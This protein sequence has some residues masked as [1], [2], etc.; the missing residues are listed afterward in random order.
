MKEIG[1]N[2][3]K[4][5]KPCKKMGKVIMNQKKMKSIMLIVSMLL[6]LGITGIPI[7]SADSPPAHAVL[8]TLY[9]NNE[10]YN[11]SLLEIQITFGYETYTGYTVPYLYDPGY[12]RSLNFNVGVPSIHEGETGAIK[13][14]YSGKSYTP[15]DHPAVFIHVGYPVPIFID[16]NCTIDMTP[17]IPPE[18]G[19]STGG[20]GSSPVQNIKPYADASAG[21]PY[22]GYVN[23]PITFNGSKSYDPDGHIIAW[24]WTFDDGNSGT[25]EIANHI[26]TLEGTY[27]VVLK[28]TDNKSATDTDQTTAIITVA[29]N[30]P[31]TPTLT[32]DPGVSGHKNISY[33]F[34]AMS[35]DADND[36]IEYI[37]S[38]GD[39]Q[40]I[41][42]DFFASGIPAT[43]SH[44]WSAAGRYVIS[45]KASDNKT[46]SGTATVAI[47][48]DAQYVGD[49][50]YLIDMNGDGIYDQFYSNSTGLTT[51]V[52][53]QDDGTY[54]INSDNDSDWDYIYDPQTKQI[55]TYPIEENQMISPLMILGS[56]IGIVA[57]LFL[58]ILL[59]T[60]RKKENQT[61]S[62]AEG[63]DATTPKKSSTKNPRKPAK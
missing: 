7:I 19:G 4:T 18:G 30:P 25:G 21:E 49:L 27:K 33:D 9:I 29:N 15:T 22:Q 1:I 28:V 58:L 20:G 16:I 11:G 50:G 56:I 61:P 57:V 26:Y 31:T 5:N 46:E 32:G 39:G 35:T 17:Y 42:T 53:L 44:T 8:G 6:S 60:R 13:V 23:Q 24:N 45:V 12:S 41:T 34:Q 63:M 37:F 47:L 48:I 2:T 10:I 51:P 14:L 3:I 55:T 36:T 43:T 54:L 52:E 59:L 38:W 62:P 40:T